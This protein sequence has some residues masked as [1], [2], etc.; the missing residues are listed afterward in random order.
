LGAIEPTTLARILA[1]AASEA[2]AVDVH[3]L[4]NHQLTVIAD[5]FVICSADNERLL[6]AFGRQIME[7]TGKIDIDPRRV[8]GSADAGWILLDYGDVVVHIFG[9][10]ERQFYRLEEVWSGAQTLLV[11]Q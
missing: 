6:R 4:D 10:A 7:A 2:K 11:I 9:E 3:V 5:L 8:E 1:E